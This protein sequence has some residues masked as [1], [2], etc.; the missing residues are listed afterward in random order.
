MEVFP[1]SHD[2]QCTDVRDMTTCMRELK[3][4]GYEQ[5]AH[6]IEQMVDEPDKWDAHWVNFCNTLLR[7]GNAANKPV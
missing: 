4:A 1:V 2:A 5:T 6:L 7:E 3:K